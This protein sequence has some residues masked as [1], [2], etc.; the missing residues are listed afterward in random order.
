MK[1]S[2]LLKP[3]TE[4]S[5][6]CEITGLC[7]DSRKVQA[8][9]L[10]IAYPGAAADGR[11]YIAEALAA[12][13]VAV[14]YE[15]REWPLRDYPPSSFLG[16]PL[17]QLARH[18][19][20]IASRFYD[21]PSKKMNVT[22]ITG[23]NGKTTIAYQLAQ[24]HALLGTRA[25]YL[26]TIGQGETNQLQPLANTT[27]DALALQSLFAHYHQRH[28][29]QVCMEVS[30]HALAQQRVD[31]IHFNQAIF[32]NLTHDHLDY[33]G[34]M[35]AYA[36][37]KAALFKKSNLQWAI[38]NRDDAYA[39]QMIAAI[40]PPCRLLTYGIYESADIRAL[41]WDVSLSGTRIDVESPWGEYQLQI[42]ALGFFNIYN[43]LAVFSS[44]L[45]AGYPHDAV[46]TVMSQLQPAPGR[47]EMVTK[48]PCV[49]VDYAHTPDALENV[50]ATLEKVK[51]GRILVVFGCGGDRDKTKRPMMGRIAGQYADIAIITSDNP[52][53]ENPQQIIQDIEQGITAHPSLYKI[54][55]REEAIAK[56][57]SLADKD[58]I[59]L[60]A[61]KGHETYQQ[62]GTHCH[63][64]SDQEIIR[65]L[66]H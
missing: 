64:F 62:I 6:D 30:S 34:T 18:L 24:A 10:F 4:V 51:K 20:A 13:A 41:D 5:G 32:T 28:I 31:C 39:E 47:M 43:A 9:D 61:G 45:A 49:I 15:P 19:A 1:W 8:G 29:D 65:G 59:I 7:N 40:H 60:V 17:P 23:T 35:E 16:A 53:T 27:P 54:E 2:E 56:A 3:W 50:L 36:A 66:L 12:G 38:V 48:K 57:V 52:R 26:G 21:D 42:N 11:L 46:V 25:A 44:L 58:D 33:H 37:A 14:V 22:G 55:N 63:H